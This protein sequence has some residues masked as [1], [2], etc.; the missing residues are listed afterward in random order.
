LA[1]LA[2]AGS[3]TGA[4]TGFT[5]YFQNAEP[6]AGYQH[7]SYNNATTLFGNNSACYASTTNEVHGVHNMAVLTNVHTTLLSGYPSTIYIHNP[8]S[9]TVSYHVVVVDAGYADSTTGALDATA[10]NEQGSFDVSIAANST[11]SQSFSSVLSQIG[12]SPS[13]SQYHAN[14]L[15][16]DPTGANS[17]PVLGQQIVTQ[18]LGGQVDMSAGCSVT[19][20]TQVQSALTSASVTR[21]CVTAAATGST[22]GKIFFQTTTAGTLT[23]YQVDPGS[24]NSYTWGTGTVTGTNFSA[25]IG[26]GG[27]GS[28]SGTITN[29]T[30]SGTYTTSKSSGT[31]S[32]ATCN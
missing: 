12:W 32:G 14:V 11:Y 5:L 20:T 31:L 13:G 7:V 30:V 8:N 24:G 25:T 21:Y 2:S 19:P 4:D 22:S 27:K 29:G 1:T 16:Y 17:A 3:P 6:W 26:N 10:G 28:A 23:L 15:V 9:S 18:S